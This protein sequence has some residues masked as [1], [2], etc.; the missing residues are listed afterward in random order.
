[1]SQETKKELVKV[2]MTNQALINGMVKVLQQKG[3]T[4]FTKVS[5]LIKILELNPNHVIESEMHVEKCT[6]CS[7][8]K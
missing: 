8:Q 5:E 2:K 7:E 3:M 1:M 6:D 4:T